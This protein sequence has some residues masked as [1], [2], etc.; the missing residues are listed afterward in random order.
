MRSEHDCAAFHKWRCGTAAPGPSGM[1]L[2]IQFSG[3]VAYARPCLCVGRAL[4]PVGK[5]PDQRLMHNRFI[6][7]RTKDIV[8]DLYRAGLFTFIIKYF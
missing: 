1:F 4:A 5:L 6:N 2:L 3:T 8:A 7:G